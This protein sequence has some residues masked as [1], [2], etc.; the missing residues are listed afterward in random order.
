MIQSVRWE[1]ILG[2][3]KYDIVPKFIQK[4]IPATRVEILMSQHIGAPSTPAVSV[5]DEVSEGQLIANAGAGLS[6]PQYA[7]IAGRVVSVDPT[8]IVIEA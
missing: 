7:S 2:I 5:G 8:K 4:K 1:E 3:H 6:L